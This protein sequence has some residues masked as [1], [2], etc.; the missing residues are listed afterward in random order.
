MSTT[1]LLRI[2]SVFTFVQAVLHTIGGV[3][4]KP[5]SAAQQAA[6][7]A[8]KSQFQVMGLTRS[9]GDFYLGMGLGITIELVVEAVV[10]W[11][12]ASLARTDASRLRPILV[13][14]LV[15]YLA[16]GVN[17]YEFFLRGR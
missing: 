2:A 9:Y 12:L 11:L 4:G 7:E 13:A 14:F 17:A 5:G 1:L 3:F 10:F 16:L 8:L 6:A 15:G